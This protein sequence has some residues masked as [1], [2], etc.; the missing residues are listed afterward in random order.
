MGGKAS[1]ESKN[2]WNKE[3]YDRILVS[4]PKGQKEVWKAKAAE[5]GKSLNAFIVEAVKEK[6]S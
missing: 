6:L 3:N 5:H 4:I 2:K 1:T